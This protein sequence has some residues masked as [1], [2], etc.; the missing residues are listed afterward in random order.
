M[1]KGTVFII[2]GPSGSGKDTIMTALFKR[3]PE[4][5]LSIS[6]VTREMRVGEVEGEKY[7]FISREEFEQQLKEDAFL[8]HNLFVDNYYGTPKKPVIDCI[9]NGDDIIVEID[10]NGAAQVREKLP[11]AVSIFIMPPSYEELKRRL[12]GRGTDSPE[13]IEKRL[14]SAL[15]EIERAVEYDYVVKNDIVDRC[16]DDI[17]HIILTQRLTVCRQKKL[18]NEV[19]N[20]C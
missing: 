4:I 18:I 13:V 6:S 12:I 15:S 16:V 17:I 7:H 3:H 2:S 8:E 1:S 11:E 10:V 19:L 14:A 9:E 20:K 5:K